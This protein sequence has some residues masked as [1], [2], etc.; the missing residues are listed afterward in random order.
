M[1]AAGAGAEAEADEVRRR[2]LVAIIRRVSSRR[3]RM[4]PPLRSKVVV[5]PGELACILSM[6]LNGEQGSAGVKKQRRTGSNEAVTR[7]RTDS[8]S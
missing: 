3:E 5:P 7:E 2:V 1:G 4:A 6:I 8:D